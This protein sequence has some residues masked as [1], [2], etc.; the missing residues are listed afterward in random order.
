MFL[1]WPV[2]CE[3]CRSKFN[4]PWPTRRGGARHPRRTSFRSRRGIE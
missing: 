2:A 1:A 3:P 4:I